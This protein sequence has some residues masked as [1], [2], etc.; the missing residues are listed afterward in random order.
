M[1]VGVNVS[2]AVTL[3]VQVREAVYVGVLVNVLVIEG[4]GVKVGV[5]PGP[6]VSVLVAVTGI[7]ISVAVRVNVAVLVAI[8]VFM[9]VVVAEGLKVNVLVGTFKLPVSNGVG[10]LLTTS[11]FVSGGFVASGIGCWS[12][13]STRE[14]RSSNDCSLSELVCESLKTS[15][16]MANST[17]GKV[18]SSTPSL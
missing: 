6:W 2:D 9:L 5:L 13:S 18:N 3:L 1:N 7:K 8:S 11:S 4:D 10:R 16:T 17:P 15:L 14:T 12:C